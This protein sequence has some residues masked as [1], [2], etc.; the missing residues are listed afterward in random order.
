MSSLGGGFPIAPLPRRGSLVDDIVAVLRER[1]LSGELSVGEQLPAESKLAEAFQVSRAIVREA[2]ARLKQEG[3]VESHQGRGV[4]I[5]RTTPEATGFLA[6]PSDAA[7]PKLKHIIE[8]RL[9][10][11]PA[12]AAHAALR[13]D[14][15]SLA[16][17]TDALGVLRAAAE[18]MPGGPEA[19]RKFHLSIAV[20]TRNPLFVTL[21]EFIGSEL[22]GAIRTARENTQKVAGRSILVHREHENIYEAILARDAVAASDAMRNHLRRAATRLSVNDSD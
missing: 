14:E 15:G 1:V 20:A 18:G 13:W 22:I 21:L 6:R 16:A 7:A 19:D 12:A 4:F 10:I 11:E 9:A 3:L 5:L 8:L 17:M 2:L